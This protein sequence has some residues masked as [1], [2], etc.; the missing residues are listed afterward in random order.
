MYIPKV[1]CMDSDTS[2]SIDADKLIQLFMHDSDL[3]LVYECIMIGECYKA[4]ESYSEH[5]FP[6]V[7]DVLYILDAWRDCLYAV[8]ARRFCEKVLADASLSADSMS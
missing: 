8:S 1:L 6:G 2:W 7:P 4:M 5:D 3:E